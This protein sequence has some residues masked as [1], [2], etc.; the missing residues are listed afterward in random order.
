MDTYEMALRECARESVPLTWA[1]IQ[2]QLGRTYHII[3]ARGD[4]DMSRRAE[5]AFEAALEV[6][7]Q[8]SG[9]IPW[10][11]IKVNL[12]NTLDQLGK[13]GRALQ[14]YQAAIQVY[15]GHRAYFECATV[16]VNM[17]NVLR[18][19]GARGDDQALRQ[20]IDAHKG[21]LSIYTQEQTPLLW[22]L[23][24]YDLGVSLLTLGERQRDKEVLRSAIDA[25]G[26]ALNVYTADGAPL[27]W[28]WVQ[29]GIGNAWRL[30]GAQGD[31]VAQDRAAKAFEA[32]LE[33]A[34]KHSGT[35][36]V[37]AIKHNL[38]LMGRL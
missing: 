29:N 33:I 38:F 8:D 32:A 23:A 3:G 4:D 36:L 30:L 27:H 21:A 14:A 9:S 5:K 6:Y 10:A 24:T 16:L 34:S 15:S 37:D 35:N 22:A 31:E 19:I 7:A 28:A 17:G 2:T 11:A 20:S 13:W 18:K 12:G 1:A 25:F 26:A